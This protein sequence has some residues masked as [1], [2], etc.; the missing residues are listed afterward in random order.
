M[1]GGHRLHRGSC[2]RQGRHLYKQPRS[3]QQPS[4]PPAYSLHH[5]GHRIG[6]VIT[7]AK[8]QNLSQVMPKHIEY[9]YLPAVD[10]ESF[11]ISQYF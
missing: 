10:H 11:D 6:A 7:A 4:H 1:E 8:G 2:C 5:A 3:S 9:L